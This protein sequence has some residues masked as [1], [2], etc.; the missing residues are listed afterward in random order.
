MRWSSAPR[1][2][3]HS[4]SAWTS[5]VRKP[6]WGSLITPPVPLPWSGQV[7]QADGSRDPSQLPGAGQIFPTAASSKCLIWRTCVRVFVSVCV[8]VCVCKWVSV[9]EQ[10]CAWGEFML[11]VLT[12]HWSVLMCCSC[13][14]DHP[15]PGH[16]S[17]SHSCVVQT[18]VWVSYCD[19]QPP[20]WFISEFVTC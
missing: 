19:L 14:Q 18:L 3:Q 12:L 1:W 10:V 6:E 9:S 16:S 8:C 15:C 20:S 5:C 2:C 7:A 11:S 13:W 4:D 17:W